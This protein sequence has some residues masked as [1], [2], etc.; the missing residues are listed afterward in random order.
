MNFNSSLWPSTP[1]FAPPRSPVPI[2]LVTKFE[3]ANDQLPPVPPI[4][5]SILSL[6]PALLY[7]YPADSISRLFDSEFSAVSLNVEAATHK[8]LKNELKLKLIQKWKIHRVAMKAQRENS[9]FRDFSPVVQTSPKSGNSRKNSLGGN[10]RKNSLANIPNEI[11]RFPSVEFEFLVDES[12][13]RVNFDDPIKAVGISL[14]DLEEFAPIEPAKENQKRKLKIN[15]RRNS[16]ISALENSFDLNKKNLNSSNSPEPSPLSRSSNFSNFQFPSATP[17]LAEFLANSPLHRFANAPSPLLTR[18]TKLRYFRLLVRTLILKDYISRCRARDRLIY[19]IYWKI[20]DFLTDF[21]NLPWDS[22]LE[23]R[24][25]HQSEIEAWARKSRKL[26]LQA[27]PNGKWLKSKQI[28]F[29]QNYSEFQSTR[30]ELISSLKQF[31]YR[32]I[33][34]KFNLPDRSENQNFPFDNSPVESLEK[35]FSTWPMPGDEPKSAENNFRRFSARNFQSENF[36]GE[37]CL[38]EL[39][40]HLEEFPALARLC[41]ADLRRRRT[42]FNQLETGLRKRNKEIQ[43]KIIEKRSKIMELNENEEELINEKEEKQRIYEEKQ[44]E[45]EKIREEIENQKKIEKKLKLEFASILKAQAIEKIEASA[46]ESIRQISIKKKMNAADEELK[47]EQRAESARILGLRESEEF[48]SLTGFGSLKKKEKFSI[49]RA[50]EILE[51]NF[52]KSHGN[53]RENEEIFKIRMNSAENSEKSTE[54]QN[55]DEFHRNENSSN[56]TRLDE[57]K[58]S[59]ISSSLIFTRV[60]AADARRGIKFRIRPQSAQGNSNSSNSQIL[61]A[62]AFR[63]TLTPSTAARILHQNAALNNS[64][65]IKTQFSSFD[66][67]I[68]SNRRPESASLSRSEISSID[69]PATAQPR[70]P[71]AVELIGGLTR[72][73]RN[74]FLER[75]Q[76]SPL[77]SEIAKSELRQQ[78]LAA[79]LKKS[80]NGKNSI[81]PNSA[82]GNFN[83]SNYFNESDSNLHHYNHSESH[84]NSSH[85]HPHTEVIRARLDRQRALIETQLNS[86]Q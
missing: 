6:P 28:Q 11:R 9:K 61:S 13:F 59:E 19:S 44:L 16:T 27:I 8:I 29:N 2:D 36:S 64:R 68:S 62:A 32:Q 22:D 41:M 49:R 53:E 72:G 42:L 54:F 10:S 67:S 65:T 50:A 31:Y 73:R 69:R 58:N 75:V 60:A 51:N 78:K 38:T 55:F 80:S 25:R 26:I 63:S 86:R 70:I 71:K 14:A 23:L 57:S 82:S 37:S 4:D 79:I 12:P 15:S 18:L 5:S 76:N 66:S 52:N 48:S 83:Q 17:S 35:F 85:P 40:A 39:F 74:K 24:P 84:S 3:L 34:E 33:R 43:E 45:L 30:N 1:S 81:R 46:R 20:F 21:L 7:S 56:S 77:F 47:A